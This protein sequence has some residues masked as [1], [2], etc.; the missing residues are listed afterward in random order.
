MNQDKFREQLKAILKD[1]NV[2]Q[3]KIEQIVLAASDWSDSSYR[4]GSDAEAYSN[5]MSGA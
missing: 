1:S 2:S 5:A 4:S 3:E